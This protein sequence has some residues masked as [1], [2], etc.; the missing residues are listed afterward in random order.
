MTWTSRASGSLPWLKKI[1]KWVTA[2]KNESWYLPLPNM[3]FQ[4]GGRQRIAVPVIELQ[5]PTYLTSCSIEWREDARRLKI[6][7][8]CC[9]KPFALVRSSLMREQ[10]LATP[11]A[12]PKHSSD[13]LGLHQ[14]R[15][16]GPDLYHQR[17]DDPRSQRSTVACACLYTYA[18]I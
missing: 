9:I 8:M 2:Q 5:A 10:T 6:S 1:H 7:F 4:F 17:R 12:H 16:L 3:T 11:K 14:V 18:V 15:V 13:R